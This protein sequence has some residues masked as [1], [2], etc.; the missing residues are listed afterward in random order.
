[1]DGW[2]EPVLRQ[3]AG[4]ASGGIHLVVVEC[5]MDIQLGERVEAGWGEASV[6]SWHN[7]KKIS[8]GLMKAGLR[9]DS[10]LQMSVLPPCCCAHHLLL[11]LLHRHLY[12][13]HPLFLLLV[14]LPGRE[15]DREEP[16]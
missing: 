15:A 14:P 5:S 12:R 7:Q 6:R 1:M 11:F 10:C 9:H 13:L 8:G 2:K 4:W 16:L 3:E